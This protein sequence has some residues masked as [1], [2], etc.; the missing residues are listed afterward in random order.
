MSQ[1]EV[2]EVIGYRVFFEGQPFGQIKTTRDEAEEYKG[3]VS[4]R[5]DP[6]SARILVNAKSSDPVFKAVWYPNGKKSPARVE[7]IRAPKLNEAKK[8]L[9]DQLDRSRLPNGIEWSQIN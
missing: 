2:K 1:W 5:W 4:K 6:D 7:K 3:R 9:R 8:I